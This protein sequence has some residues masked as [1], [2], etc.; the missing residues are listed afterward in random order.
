MVKSKACTRFRQYIL[1]KPTKWGFKVWVLANNTGYTVDFDL[2]VGKET[3]I[4][5]K[6][7]SYDVMKLVQPLLFQ[8]YELYIDNFY[9]SPTLLS[10]S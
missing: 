8:G 6:G 10:G 7:L 1:N 9:T 5:N 4:S 3:Q 2:Y